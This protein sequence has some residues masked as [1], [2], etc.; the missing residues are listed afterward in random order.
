MTG[1]VY[2][3]NGENGTL[4]TGSVLLAM[5]TAADKAT[6][7]GELAILRIEVFQNASVTAGQ[8]RLEMFTRDTAGTLTMTSVTPRA[9][10]P[11]NGPASAIT[12]STAPAGTA[13]K[14]GFNSSADS[15]G[16][17]VTVYNTNFNNLNGYLWVP[18]P[19]ERI[20]IPP[21]TVWGLR[22]TANPTSTTGWGVAVTYAEL[23]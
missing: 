17:Y 9:L 16:T 23:N 6:A 12:G 1:R 5:R 13:A 8:C 11:L 14:V 18:T 15:G 21:A 3:V 22:F 19:E 7:G 10:S 20:I 2:T 4:G